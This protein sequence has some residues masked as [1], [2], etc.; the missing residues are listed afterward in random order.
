MWWFVKDNED[1]GN[2]YNDSDEVGDDCDDYVYSVNSVQ[3]HYY[4]A[5]QQQQSK[6]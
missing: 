3:F 6:K 5:F 4:I 2:V 1:G